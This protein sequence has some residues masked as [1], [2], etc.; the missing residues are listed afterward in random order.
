MGK[1]GGGKKVQKGA[2]PYQAE[3]KK[4]DILGKDRER[5][6]EEVGER[7]GREWRNQETK[8]FFSREVRASETG[9][10]KGGVEVVL[11]IPIDEFLNSP[12]KGKPTRGRTPVS[13]C[14]YAEGRLGL[15]KKEKR[16]GERRER[17]EGPVRGGRREAALLKRGRGG[18]PQSET[19]KRGEGRQENARFQLKETRLQRTEEH[20]GYGTQGGEDC[21]VRLVDE[22]R[23]PIT[24]GR[25]RRGRKRNGTQEDGKSSEAQSGSSR[26]EGLQPMT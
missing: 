19:G 1:K 16:P 21:F 25:R 18:R 13:A 24:K 3:E 6:I 20:G 15:N 12:K 5:L 26:E 8:K 22:R 17:G 10:E 7:R 11:G 9:G 14:Y 2:N 23:G 4:N